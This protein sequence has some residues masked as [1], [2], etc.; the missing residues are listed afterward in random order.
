MSG[1]TSLEED[2][3]R[4]RASWFETIFALRRNAAMFFPS[5]LQSKPRGNP[6]DDPN[7]NVSRTLALSKLEREWRLDKERL[8]DEGGGLRD[9]ERG[10][11]GAPR[12]GRRTLLGPTM[13]SQTSP[14][15]TR[16]PE[17]GDA[18]RTRSGLERLA[19]RS[20][21]SRGNAPL[22]GSPLSTPSPAVP[23][24]PSA[25]AVLQ[26]GAGRLGVGSSDKAQ[27]IKIYL[28]TNTTLVFKPAYHASRAWPSVWRTNANCA[29]S[30]H[31]KS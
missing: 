30:L 13:T 6:D 10:V 7:F 27:G 8:L 31:R 29:P 4:R 26:G 9:D 24:S 14:P 16:K 2:G 25:I 23:S 22:S 19:R 5:E 12:L 18:P 3:Q 28:T 21:S 15:Y 11:T 20:S 17:R 1:D